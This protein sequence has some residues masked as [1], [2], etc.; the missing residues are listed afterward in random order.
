LNTNLD[1]KTRSYLALA[2]MVALGILIVAIVGEA[3]KY[4]MPDETLYFSLVNKVYI[5]AAAVLLLTFGLNWVNMGSVKNLI[6]IFVMLLI[7]LVVL[8]QLDKV[9]S[10][11]LW[12]G[13]YP[14]VY[15][16]VPERYVTLFLQ[17]LD[18]IG[19]V[20]G[21]L[22][23]FLVMLKALDR[24]KDSLGGPAKNN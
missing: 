20:V 18:V 15:G 8:W 1:D 24:A 19:I 11:V 17:S 21:A 5:L 10:G 6:A 23:A 14:S 9:G 2:V 13:M 12:N 4:V 16:R 22:G 3:A 7:S